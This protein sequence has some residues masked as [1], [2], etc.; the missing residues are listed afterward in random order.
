MA[1][2]VLPLKGQLKAITAF[3][4]RQCI[5]VLRRHAALCPCAVNDYHKIHN[6]FKSG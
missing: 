6:Q 4:T 1:I 5:H 3:H 2:A